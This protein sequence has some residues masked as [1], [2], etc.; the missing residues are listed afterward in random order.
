M[1]DATLRR[2]IRALFDVTSNDGLAVGG[3]RYVRILPRG[4]V[5]LRDEGERWVAEF[6]PP[7]RV[8]Q[9]LLGITASLPCPRVIAERDRLIVE[10]DGWR[11]EIIHL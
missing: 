3:G 1:N 4:S 2:A 7:A 11:D 10:I 9:S 8:G 5:L 6:T